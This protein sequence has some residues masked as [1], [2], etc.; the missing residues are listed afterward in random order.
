MTTIQPL[1][2]SDRPLIEHARELAGHYPI[3]TAA[4]VHD[5]FARMPIREPEQ[6]GLALTVISVLSAVAVLGALIAWWL[7]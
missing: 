4:E 7:L 1:E 2:L 6:S 5:A 3:M